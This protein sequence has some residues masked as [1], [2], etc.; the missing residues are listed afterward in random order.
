ML[1]L[2]IHVPTNIKKEL[3]HVFAADNEASL[4]DELVFRVVRLF[5]AQEGIVGFYR[6]NN[7]SN[8]ANNTTNQPVKL[9]NFSFLHKG[10]NLSS[11][12]ANI[13]KRL[14]LDSGIHNRVV[15]ELAFKSSPVSF[16]TFSWPFGRAEYSSSSNNTD[17][18]ATNGGERGNNDIDDF[19]ILDINFPRAFTM[20]VPFT[21]RLTVSTPLDKEFNGYL[22]IFFDEFPDI[23][24]D[25]LQLIVTLPDLISNLMSAYI[26]W[27]SSEQKF[28][29]QDQ[30]IA[31]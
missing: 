13:I 25:V 10:K 18:T 1:T 14:W 22:A 28:N 17:D 21:S 16:S 3:A 19:D 2:P 27:N 20:L 31:S 11:H 23:T 7:D 6:F 26:R 8:I 4:I 15:Q 29:I 5:E 30:E 24:E 12:S 9:Y